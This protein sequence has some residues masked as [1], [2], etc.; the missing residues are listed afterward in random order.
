M[1]EFLEEGGGGAGGHADVCGV[2]HLRAGIRYSRGDACFVESGEVIQ[3][4]EASSSAYY[5]IYRVDI[6][7]GSYGIYTDT[8]YIYYDGYGKTPRILE[9]DIVTFYGRYDGL[10]SYTTVMGATVTLPCIYA[11]Y[12]EIVR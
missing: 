12:I 3:V 8:V 6:T 4:V 2:M 11:E 5:C 10:T 1:A 9:D 7:R